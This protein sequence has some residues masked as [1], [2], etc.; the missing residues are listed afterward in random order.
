MTMRLGLKK[1]ARVAGYWG[2]K[3][4]CLACNRMGIHPICGCG[5]RCDRLN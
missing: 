5:K 2:S 3:F 4:I 1:I